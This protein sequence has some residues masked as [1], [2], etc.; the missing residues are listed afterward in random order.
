[1]KEPTYLNT[2]E[3][4]DEKDL[5]PT[6]EDEVNEL[7]EASKAQWQRANN[8]EQ[9]IQCLENDLAKANSDLQQ[10]RNADD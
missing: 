10:A 9:R 7:R 6:P 2:M 4:K 8:A 5:Y 1:M 3:E